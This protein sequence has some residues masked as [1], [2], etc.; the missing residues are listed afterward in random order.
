MDTPTQM[1]NPPKDQTKMVAPAKTGPK[2]VKVFAMREFKIEKLIKNSHGDV[3]E[4]QSRMVKPGEV[5]EVTE[6][7]ARELIKPIK[8]AYA[9]SGERHLADGDC[10]QHDL[11]IARLATKRDLIQERNEV[12]T[13]LEAEGA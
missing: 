5:V 3:I 7:K 6:A 9:F 4:D 11:T 1:Q 13:P 10:H 2:M 12:L 8:G